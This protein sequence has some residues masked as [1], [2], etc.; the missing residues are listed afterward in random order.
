M[1]NVT[2]MA[3]VILFIVGIIVTLTYVFLLFFGSAILVWTIVVITVFTA[4][5]YE[6]YDISLW[7]EEQKKEAEKITVKS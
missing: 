7:E 4:L 1:E 5:I 2:A 6:I 3:L